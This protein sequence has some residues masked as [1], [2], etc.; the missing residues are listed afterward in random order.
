VPETVRGAHVPDHPGN[1][2]QRDQNCCTK[3]VTPPRAWSRTRASP[4]VSA[5]G[6]R[7]GQPRRA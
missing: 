1:R 4:T 7:S 6:P 5:S 3:D 2:T